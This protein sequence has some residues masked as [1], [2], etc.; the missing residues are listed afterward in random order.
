MTGREVHLFTSESVT[1]GH[2]DKVADQISDS[3]LDGVLRED[4]EGRVACETLVTTGLVMLAGEI[5]TRARLD[6][7]AIA[8]QTI[9]DIGYTKV[10]FGFDADSCGVVV[11]VGRQ[12]PNIAQG[13]DTGGAGDQGLMFGFACRETPQLMPMPIM[14]A[15]GLTRRMAQAR[16]SGEIA[17][18]RPDGKSQVTVEYEGRTPVRVHTVVVSTHHAKGVPQQEIRE[19]VV[20]QIIRPTIPGHLL[21]ERTVFHVNPTGS[22]EIGGPQG[23]CGLTGRKIIVDTYGGVGSHG[24]GAFSG[25]DPTKVDRSASYMARHIAKNLVAAGL[26]ER[27][28]VQLAYAIGVAEPVSVHVD[29]SG[30]GLVSDRALERLVR[31]EFELTPRGIIDYLDLRRPIYRKTAAYGHFGREGEGF[32]WEETGRASELR[33]AAG[34]S[35]QIPAPT[36]V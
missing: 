21:D 30:T 13:V 1:E 25:K 22:F 17:W 20:E 16:R 28:E 6:F 2:P 24:G 19:V 36:A 29:T 9:R 10:D 15:H 4:A 35:G 27:V 18:L 12:S 8:R 14:L 11:S 34:M 3:V 7:M 5:S 23:D 26:A 33:A 31:S 32:H